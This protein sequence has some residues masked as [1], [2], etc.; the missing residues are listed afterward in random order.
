MR[1]SKHVKKIF[2]YE[3]HQK[4][5]EIKYLPLDSKTNLFKRNN[6]PHTKS[7]ATNTSLG[8]GL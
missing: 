5:I 7:L 1:V 4:Q 8:R 2:K 3:S 6:I